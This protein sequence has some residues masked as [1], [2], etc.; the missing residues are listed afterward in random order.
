VQLT[1][2]GLPSDAGPAKLGLYL[3]PLRIAAKTVSDAL[4]GASRP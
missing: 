3:E 4:S 1:L 2:Y